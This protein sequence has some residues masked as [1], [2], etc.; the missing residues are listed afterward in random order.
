MKRPQLDELLR[1]RI[2]V[3]DGAM[4]S[5]IQSF[6]LSEQDFRGTVFADH[7]HDLKGNNDLLSLT[8][9]DVIA[10]IHNDYLAAGADLIET[11]TFN[12][13]AISQADYGTEAAVY[14]MN[15][16]AARI[17]RQ[18]AD[19]FT[20]QDPGTPRYVAGALG[21]TNKTASMSQDVGDP[22]ARAVRFDHL[23]AAYGEQ[24]RGLLDGGADLLL[25]ETIFDT[26][27]GKAAL[28]ALEELF[29][30]RGERTPVIVSGTI[31]DASGRTL[32]GQTVEAFWASV[33]H[34]PLLAVGFNC[35]LGPTE[36]RP[37][38][39]AIAALADCFLSCYPNAGLPNDLGGYDLGPQEMAEL[40]GEFARAG[41]VHLVGGCC[42][43][44]PQHVEALAQAVRGLQ[45]PPLKPTSN[46]ACFSGLE[47]LQMRSDL[48]F[49]NVGERTNVAGSKKFARL[50]QA[51]QR[52]EA[53]AV[54]RQQVEAGAQIIDVCMDE[55]LLDGVEEMT[56]F[57]DL[58][59]S[60]PD[61]A[62]VPVMVDSSR[63][64]VIEA[65]L[66]CLQGRSIVNSISLKDGDAE[67]RRR[68]RLAHRYGAAVVVMAFDEH[69]QATDVA[70]RL[71]ICR[72]SHRILAEIGFLDQHVIFD[73]NVL[74][75]ATGMS[76]HDD[77]ARSF[78]DAARA[79]KQEYPHCLLSG[80]ISNLSFAFRGVEPVR[81][82][83]HAVFLFHACAAGLDMGIV[84]AGQL[85]FYH[86]LD[87]QVRELVEDVIFNRRA[88]A[89]ERLIDYAQS[90]RNL[91]PEERQ[92][93]VKAWRQLPLAERL[94]HALVHGISDHLE[95]DLPA[96][97]E[98]CGTALQVIEGPLM[99]GM[100]VVGDLFGSG[101]MFLPQVVKSARV[102]KKAVAWLQPHLQEDGAP[103]RSRG[104]ILLATVKGDVHDIG[105]NIVGVIL[106][107]NGYEILDLG[108]MVPFQKILETA[109]AEQVQII[110][111]SGLITPSLEEMAHNAGE[112]QRN[113]LDLPLL[114]GGATTSA[115]HTAVRIA[116]ATQGAVVHVKDASRAV[117][118]V[119]ELL[120]ADRVA[121]FVQDNAT[122]QDKLRRDRAAKEERRLGLPIAVARQR[123]LD[124]RFGPSEVAAPALPGVHVFDDFPLQ[125][126]VPRID[127]TPF[128]S[129]WELK[130][131]FP[132]ILDDA[133]V[134][135]AARKLHQEAEQML[136][137]MVGEQILRARAVIALLPANSRDQ[138]VEVYHGPDRD[139]VAARLP[140][141]R[142]QRDAGGDRPCVSLADF[143]APAD[144][145]IADHLGF[146]ALS[147]GFGL[148]EFVAG[149]RA[150]HDDYQAILA[151]AL[152]DRL[153]EAF[154][155][156]LHERV[157]QHYWGYESEDSLSND[158]L[159]R[160][161]YRGIR[162][163]PGYPACPDHRLKR[164][165][166]DLLQVEQH[167]GIDLSENWAMLPGASVSGFYFSH[168]QA[169]YFGVGTP[170]QDQIEWL[171][172][173]R[174]LENDMCA[175][176][177]GLALLQ[178]TN[179]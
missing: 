18:A 96:A 64:E 132:A 128:F 49:V 63:W 25:V 173:Q 169:R 83:M 81:K 150:D 110:G 50:I 57:L 144:S 76:E 141:L 112:M 119:Q 116:P 73:L 80:G 121:D 44:T 58:V 46:R 126:L 37:H 23:V 82:A 28:F 86:D 89:A 61:I 103:V 33:A 87:P 95:E 143:V 125:E 92:A 157:R 74:A 175:R 154:A 149:F 15:V 79:V 118:V 99:D 133:R 70:R 105:K 36:L 88:D 109:R 151:E 45:P 91:D 129:T 4:G 94:G 164:D 66:K 75:V 20:E 122:R 27:N 84:N 56:R 65:G 51:G 60:E 21:P 93:E 78:I 55:A 40:V 22:G 12:A 166:F 3:M 140:M 8:R 177:L 34:I 24:A 77:Y 124:L 19:A 114:I 160:E 127:W 137:Q 136:E 130:G 167:T 139:Q 120:A 32:S 11:N 6:G 72:R 158:A 97:L 111:L 48:N 10:G 1:Q 2:L 179:N 7:G 147:T 146:F 13:N 59:A 101:R 17:A 29:D 47:A 42:G 43:T 163:A 69:G 30:Q 102:M 115:L 138:C 5:L 53:L 148:A 131:R 68:A 113:G 38:M 67:F 9:P 14:D 41:L 134:G 26:L 174:G 35:A 176:G 152:A 52:E 161:Q 172:L 90:V 155:E 100:D 156:R 98:A 31:T 170:A 153:A 142:Q 135:E 85:D 178:P 16:A 117:G 145:G 62:R 54:A 108:V 159:L 168:P 71:E 107:C 104:R 39:E 106:G 171:A 165:L 162:P 123:R